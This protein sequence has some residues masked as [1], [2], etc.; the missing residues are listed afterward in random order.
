MCSRKFEYYTED[1]LLAGAMIRGIQ[2]SGVS[3]RRV[4]EFMLKLD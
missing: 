2:S 1:P 3:A 4:C